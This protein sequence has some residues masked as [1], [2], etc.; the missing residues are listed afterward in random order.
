MYRGVSRNGLSWQVMSMIDCQSVYLATTK[1]PIEAALIYDIVN[2][3]TK[4][5]MARVNFN[6]SARELLAILLSEPLHRLKMKSAAPIVASDDADR[7]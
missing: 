6:Y 3:Q 7:C 5:M 1:D 2:L 4:G